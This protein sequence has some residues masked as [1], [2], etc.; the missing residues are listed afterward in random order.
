MY[1]IRQ[2]TKELNLVVGPRPFIYWWIDIVRPLPIA[3][4][5]KKF[6]L[7]ATD[8]FTKWVEA[9]A[10]KTRTLEKRKGKWSKELPNVLWAYRITK[11]KPIGESPF[12]LA[13]GT[14]A[15]IPTEIGLPTVRTLVV[16]SNDNEQQLAH[17][18]DMLEEQRETAALQLANYQHQATNYFN[19]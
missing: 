8:Y 17:S 16:E 3:V 2:P 1:P 6:V 18:L 15:V 11:R 5:G 14:E 9:E 12:S 13:Y 4:E 7:L 19:K 10:Y